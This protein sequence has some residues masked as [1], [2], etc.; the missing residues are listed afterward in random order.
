[1]QPKPS[2]RYET[3]V[4]VCV[5]ARACG[6]SQEKRLWVKGKEVGGSGKVENPEICFV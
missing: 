1:M 2:L 4:C 6:I 5:R 3:L